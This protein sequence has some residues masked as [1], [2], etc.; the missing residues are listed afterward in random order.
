MDP[1]LDFM[2]SQEELN[3]LHKKIMDTISRRERHKVFVDCDNTGDVYDRFGRNVSKQ[4]RKQDSVPWVKVVYKRG[5]L[6]IPI[7]KKNALKTMR[8]M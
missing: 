4:E 1:T 6:Y 2:P 5:K 3:I 7:N 8:L